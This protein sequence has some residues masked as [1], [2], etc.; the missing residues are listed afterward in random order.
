MS[1]AE[2]REGLP[3]CVSVAVFEGRRAFM[4]D[5]RECE[6]GWDHDRK[7]R[8]VVVVDRVL[9]GSS[10]DGYHPDCYM[11][12]GDGATNVLTLWTDDPDEARDAFMKGAEWVRT[13]ELE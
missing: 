12:W 3:P 8:M 5:I 6:H 11:P 4:R 10:P 1:E 9:H 13:G 2:P 7:E